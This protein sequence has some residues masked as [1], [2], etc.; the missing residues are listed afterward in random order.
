MLNALSAAKWNFQTAAHLLNRAGFGGTPADIEK[1]QKLGP[2]VAVD[3][4]VDYDRIPDTT[5]P[6]DWAKPDGERMT[7]FKEAREF[8]EKMRSATPEERK[9]LEA[10]AKQVRQMF[11]K[12]QRQH[13]VEM[14]G[15]WL[16]R[17][18]KGPRPL[19]EKLTLF[20]H[21]HFATSIQKVKDA[22]LMYLQNET[23]R[24]H[25]SGN[26]LEM[27]KAVTKDPAMLV[28]L[29]Q[30]QSK[31]QHPNENYAREVMELFALGEGHYTEKDI[32]EAAR[33]FTGL[34]YNRLDQESDYRPFL[35]DATEKTVLGKTGKLDWEDVLEQIVAQP[36]APKF[37]CAKLWTFFVADN[38]SD[39]IID[40]LATI[41][42]KHNNEFK[43]V[44]RAIFRSEEFYAESMVRTQVK[45]PVQWLVSSVRMLERELPPAPIASNVLMTLS[46]DLFAPPNVKGW[47]GGLTWITTNNLL[48]RYNL[49]EALVYGK[50]Q[51]QVPKDKKGLK[52]VANRL[53]RRLAQGTPVDPDKLVSASERTSK[54]ALL[55]ALE[56]RL[57]QAE[58]KPKQK[59]ALNEYLDGQ[60]ELDSHDVLEAVRLIM[61]TP[62]FQLT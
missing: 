54:T 50:N 16:E 11:Q 49:A 21:G 58:L 30:A 46:Q 42:R 52:F 36:Q 15:W 1:L 41:F 56:R 57:L 35:H 26:W 22:Y 31:K 60:G 25:A 6:P 40:A 7:K 43:P 47:D 55:A 13:V 9:A 39:E 17:M 53:N 44:L 45:S 33:A 18:A 24:K 3:S 20:W 38:P 2:D 8:R 59:K 32:T 62:E 4:L 29:D 48:S 28:W 51:I 61:S 27:L 10:K 5:E 23:F 34:T 12:N 14:R 37:I 19:Q